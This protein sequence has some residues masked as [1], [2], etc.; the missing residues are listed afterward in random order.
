M[1]NRFFDVWYISK[2][3]ILYFM[4]QA[5]F[6]FLCTLILESVWGIA[7]GIFLASAA[8]LAH[9]LVFGYFGV[10]KETFTSVKGKNLLYNILLVF[11]AMYAMN[12]AVQWFSLEDKMEDTF[13]ALTHNILGF[14]SISILGP[15][16]EEVLFRGAIQGYLMRRYNPMVAIITASLVFG[17]VHMNP[18]QTVYASCLGFVFG[19]IYYRTGTLLPVILGHILNNFL[20]SSLMISGIDESEMQAEVS[21]SSELSI[22]IFFVAVALLLARKIDSITPPV[23]SPWRDVC[24][25]HNQTDIL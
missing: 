10:C 2:L 3:I 23:P 22:V 7:A 5:V 18:I 8:M 24:E 17:I 11:A 9:L 19:W 15:L 6:T 13:Q 20:A 14:V 4:Y 1:K 25:R 16:L 21:F 12:I